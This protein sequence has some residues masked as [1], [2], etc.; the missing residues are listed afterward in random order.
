M[1]NDGRVGTSPGDPILE[2]RYLR[3]AV[4]RSR[5]R[6][7]PIRLRDVLPAALM[8]ARFG[9]IL[10]LEA[11]TAYLPTLAVRSRCVQRQVYVGSGHF[12]CPTDV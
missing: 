6:M 7:I 8:D 4:T 3:M 2:G 1:T 11:T 12:L 5:L 9:R 10:R